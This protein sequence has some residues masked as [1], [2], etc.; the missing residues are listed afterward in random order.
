MPIKHLEM[1]RKLP[2]PR[3]R[4]STSS[5]PLADNIIAKY[6]INFKNKFLQIDEN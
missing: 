3:Q 1:K 2:F 4:T 5:R 6:D